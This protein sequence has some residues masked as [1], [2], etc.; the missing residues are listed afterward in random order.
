MS[1][2]SRGQGTPGVTGRGTPDNQAPTGPCPK[3]AA[4]LLEMG[5]EAFARQGWRLPEACVG[6]GGAP[7]VR[8]QAGWAG[9]PWE[10][11]G[12]PLLLDVAL[13]LSP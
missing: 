8:P 4:K 10:G 7:A 6:G 9:R 1:P 2:S 12:G 13:C 11:R 5:R 3:V